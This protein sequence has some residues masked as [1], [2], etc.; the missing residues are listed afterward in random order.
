MPSWFDTAF[1]LAPPADGTLEW[2]DTALDVLAYRMTYGIT[3]VVITLE[4]ATPRGRPA[5]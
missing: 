2:L 5:T 3:D 1:N 4:F